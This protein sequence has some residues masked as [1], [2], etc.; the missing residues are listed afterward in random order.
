[1]SFGCG[2]VTCAA[3][4]AR[5]TGSG[6]KAAGGDSA[7]GIQM[8]N[9]GATPNLTAFFNTINYISGSNNNLT[10]ILG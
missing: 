3:V 2:G 5:V 9:S 10:L 1:M 6:L 7:Y 4:Y 8:G